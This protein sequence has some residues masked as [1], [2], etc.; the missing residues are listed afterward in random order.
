MMRG[1]LVAVCGLLLVASLGGCAARQPAEPAQ[2]AAQ[3]IEPMT[4]SAKRATIATGFP[5]EVPVPVGDFSRAEAQGDDAWD[6]VVAVTATPED[7]AQWYRAAYGGRQWELSGEEK[8]A[9]G[10]VLT[11][12]KGTAES[13]VSVT[14]DPEGSA[15]TVVVGVGAPV[16]QTQ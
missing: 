10:V 9:E 3:P 2:P 13:R 1:L 16:I 11:F 14:T 8:T 5:A 7:L 12:R 4:P 6:Y 15:A